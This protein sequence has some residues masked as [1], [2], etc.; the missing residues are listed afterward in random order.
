M[1]TLGAVSCG[2][3]LL[4][5]ACDGSGGGLWFSDLTDM[6]VVWRRAADA[7]LLGIFDATSALDPKEFFICTVLTEASVFSSLTDILVILA[8]AADVTIAL[9]EV[10]EFLEAGTVL[11]V[12]S[13]T[14]LD[15]VLEM[16]AAL[17]EDT[18][19]CI[20]AA[21]VL[22]SSGLDTVAGIVVEVVLELVALEVEVV[23]VSLE[24]FA[25]HLERV[26]PALEVFATFLQAV[27][28]NVV[29]AV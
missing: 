15:P 25:V 24:A 27:S 29:E 16:V 26:A 28:L 7:L 18:A 5:E 8:V 22:L 12:T 13:R 20:D 11:L 4:A 2:F 14:T 6:S 10:S 21:A 17:D 19:T 9:D 23:P 1:P 3:V